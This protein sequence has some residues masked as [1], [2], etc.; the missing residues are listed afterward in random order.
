MKTTSKLT[1]KIELACNSL[2]EISKKDGGAA[3][4]RRELYFLLERLNRN[5]PIGCCGADVCG[6]DGTCFTQI[7]GQGFC[8]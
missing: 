8:K 4:A 5:L 3:I 7:S 2:T 1:E 6:V